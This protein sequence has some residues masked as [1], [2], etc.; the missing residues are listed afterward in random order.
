LSPL[1]PGFEPEAAPASGLPA[2]FAPETPE[3]KLQREHGGTGAQVETLLRNALGT[4]SFGLSDAAAM[5]TA[6]Q[7][8]E[9]NPL[10]AL[11]DALSGREHL[12][13]GPMVTPQAMAAEMK[14]N[15]AAN[16]WAK[17]TGVAA[18]VVLPGAAGAIG[19]AGGAAARAVGSVLP[20]ATSLGGKALVGLG[21]GLAQGA[22]EGGLFSAGDVV[23][24]AALDPDL[25][26]Q[27]MAD[28][29]GLGSMLGAGLSGPLG[30]LG[31]LA[32]GAATTGL[33]KK[34]GEWAPKFEG[35]QVVKSTNAMP[36]LIKGMRKR[37]G[38]EELGKIAREAHDLGIASKFSTPAA[39][40]ERAEA[41]KEAAVN[42]QQTVLRTAQEAGA[43]PRS[44]E[45]IGERIRKEVLSELEANPLREGLAGTVEKVVNKWESTFTKD[46]PLTFND[47]HGLRKWA[48][49]EIRGLKGVFD[50]QGSQLKASLYDIRSVLA[51]ELNKG[52]D[53]AGLSSNAWKAAN[54]KYRVAATMEELAQSGADRAHANNPMHLTSSLAGLTGFATHGV[55][56][57]A[58]MGLATEA[59]KRFAPGVLAAGAKALRTGAEAAPGMA[60]E[61]ASALAHIQAANE[62]VA[63]KVGEFL[64]KAVKGTPG[65][66]Q[67]A[68][69]AAAA[70]AASNTN[71]EEKMA[72]VQRVAQ[73][74]E[75][76]HGAMVAHTDDLHEHSPATAQAL[77]VHRAQQI[78]FLAS[79]LPKLPT[80]GP[81]GPKLEHSKEAKW[82][83]GRYYDAVNQPTSILKHAA[84]GT[85]T[86]MDVE[87]V[88]STAPA[89]Y[90]HMVTTALEKAASHKG[91]LPYR[92]RL[93]LSML[94]G[95]D[96]DGSLSP[97]A[98]NSAQ[99]VYALPSQKSAEDKTGPAATGRATQTGMGKLSVSS[100]A[101]L[102]G[103]SAER[104]RGGP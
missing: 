47:L 52:L 1:P 66:I 57:G 96:M 62:S 3:E 71:I 99:A 65:T 89:L 39:M 16:P 85:L 20:E 94:A 12:Q 6:G 49:S 79:K 32:K 40:V 53:D 104:R 63:T 23:K 18:G 9:N 68:I 4:A 34:L 21:K 102:P 92:A 42:E 70:H 97:Q 27:A 98:I 55:G 64:D 67:K 59:A 61:A 87:A 30:A 100:M 56:G 51:D 72:A 48:D 73:N 7:P 50:P 95:A 90:K 76:L 43:L 46:K 91:P 28:E 88:K 22:V 77:Q 38:E 14:A 24:Q 37:I 93:T 5:S 75:Q 36:A 82:K 54:R 17:A 33:A 103:Q 31:Q 10:G 74:P 15:D 58:L 13:F 8:T 80:T 44:M 11:K 29:I 78:G 26:A 25:S 86:P 101:S 69:G 81:L 45:K 83:F 2:G 60:P 19:K 35:E 41:V 84:K